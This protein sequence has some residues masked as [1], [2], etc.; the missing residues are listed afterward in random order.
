V[1]EERFFMRGRPV[2]RSQRAPQTVG[3]GKWPV[4]RA[5]EG[6]ARCP[7]RT[8]GERA[9]PR[10]LSRPRQSLTAAYGT[11]PAYGLVGAATSERRIALLSIELLTLV[12]AP[13][14]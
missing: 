7:E 4:A 6:S 3:R 8:R 12:A 5:C 11:R 14:R 1:L 13:P 9:G 10:A 2:R